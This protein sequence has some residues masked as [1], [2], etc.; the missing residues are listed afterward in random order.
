MSASIHLSYWREEINH[1]INEGLSNPGL[2]K[3]LKDYAKNHTLSQAIH[4]FIDKIQY[5]YMKY[6]EIELEHFKKEV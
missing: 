1:A 3:E 2:K 6:T 5:Y 4:Y